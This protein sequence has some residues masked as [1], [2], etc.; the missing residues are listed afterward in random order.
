MTRQADILPCPYCGNEYTVLPNSGIKGRS[1]YVQCAMP[2]HDG[3]YDYCGAAGPG[4]DNEEEAIERWNAGPQPRIEGVGVLTGIKQL[5]AGR[6]C[7]FALCRDG[8]VWVK[9]FMGGEP[10]PPW[11]CESMHIEEEDDVNE[12]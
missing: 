12:E 5:T 8:S 10:S 6:G 7:L 11:R 1:Q 2:P 3:K 4:Y 9:S